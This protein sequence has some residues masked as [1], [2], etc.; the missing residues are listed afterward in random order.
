MHIGID[1]GGTNL[2]GGIMDRSGNL[3]EI[4]TRPVENPDDIFP[5]INSFLSGY[6]SNFEIKSCGIGLPGVISGGRVIVSPNIPALDGAL[7]AEEIKIPHGIPLA[8]ENDANTAALAELTEGAGKGRDYFIYVTLG[9]GIGGAIIYRGEILKGETGGAGEIGH[10]IINAFGE[11]PVKNDFRVGTL[12]QLAGRA[13]IL[14]I[15]ENISPGKYPDVKDI[16][17]SAKQN[18]PDA[19]DIINKISEIVS[20]GIISAMN[21]LDIR[22]VIIGGGISLIG[23]RLF[24]NIRENIKRR[25]LPSVAGKFEILQAHFLYNTGIAGAALLG[26][27]FATSKGVR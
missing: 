20:L 12:E 19:I 22:T 14:T 5:E 17:E 1:I 24:H 3:T 4:R 7:L 26:K 11:N 2:K 8:F 18:S 6:F 25:A 21:L 13:G 15:A 10:M 23:G 27:H 9:T 16:A